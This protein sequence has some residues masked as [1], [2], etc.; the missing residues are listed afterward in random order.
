M[1]KLYE[2]SETGCCLRFD[3]AP[4][5]N[6]EISWSDKLFLKDHVTSFFH[7]PLNFGSVIVKN[8]ERIKKADALSDIPIMLSDENSLWG[9]TIYIAVGSEVPGATMVRI[10]GTYLSKIFE[11]SFG[12]MGKWV[13]EMRDY[14]KEQGKALKKLYFYYTTCPKC[15]KH[16]GKNYVVLLAQI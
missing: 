16:Y 10:S 6:K 13:I 9:A 15:A 1:K 7:I 2:K 14:V 8:M 12:N 4:W 5:D 11:G 3:P